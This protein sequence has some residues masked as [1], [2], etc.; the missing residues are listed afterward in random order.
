M[1]YMDKSFVGSMNEVV[2]Y[3]LEEKREEI[4]DYLEYSNFIDMYIGYDG[5]G[6]DELLDR[7]MNVFGYMEN[8]FRELG[9]VGEFDS[10][11]RE[12]MRMVLIEVGC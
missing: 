2:G 12:E 6:L 7:Y 8:R 9:Y 3:M 11:S 4:K 1:E 10:S 5:I